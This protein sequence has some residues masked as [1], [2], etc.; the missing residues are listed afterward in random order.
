MPALVYK[1]ARQNLFAYA[2]ALRIYFSRRP[3]NGF[4]IQKILLA[5]KLK[6]GKVTPAT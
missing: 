1:G 2:K 3:G 5:L 4:F 6:Y